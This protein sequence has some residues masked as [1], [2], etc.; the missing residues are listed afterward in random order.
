MNQTGFDQGPGPK[1]KRKPKR[2]PFQ[3]ANSE[4]SPKRQ[5]PR[6]T[7]VKPS[8]EPA[9]TPFGATG[10]KAKNIVQRGPANYGSPV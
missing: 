9:Q 3:S 1:M 10:R 2:A 4:M 7:V 5:R 8:S 6:E